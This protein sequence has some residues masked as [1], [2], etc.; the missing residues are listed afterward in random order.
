M[1]L[2]PALIRAALPRDR[3]YTLSDGGGMVLQ[4]TPQGRKR[5]RLR[6]RYC[7][8]P[9][10][11]SLGLYPEVGLRAARQQRAEARGLLA[12]G[13]NP[14]IERRTAAAEVCTFA[15]VAHDWLACLT[16][17]VEK[18]RRSPDVLRRARW[19]LNNHLLP[20]LGPRPIAKITAYELLG[21][22]KSIE[23]RGL[24]DTVR[25]VRQQASRILRHAVGLGY[26][27]YDLTAG[28][29]GLLLPPHPQHR[30]GITNPK[31]L[32]V[33]LRAVDSYRGAEKIAIALKLTPLL[34]V[35][36]GELRG[37]EWDEIDFERA[38]W[39]IPAERMK[40]RT[41]H[42]VPLCRQAL[43]FLERLHS[44]TG[45]GRYLFPAH[46]KPDRTMSGTRLA[47][48]LA[49]L[50]FSSREVTPHGFRA[51]ACT[52]LNELGWRADAIE[53]QLAHA[54]GDS[55]RRLYNHAQYLP[56]RTMMMQAWADYLDGLR[57]LAAGRREWGTK[58]CVAAEAASSASMP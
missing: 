36:P 5:W 23:S 44:L 33:L 13:F 14:S 30:P 8:I 35:R 6:Y 12:L 27:P 57:A 31:R 4:V 10:M 48:A 1:P 18:R 7:G 15:A 2:T 26:I 24:L 52:L 45:D 38:Q 29:R 49:S 20:A 39:R 42:L 47:A 25:R 17:I 28:F 54:V 19:V 51:T 3:L 43:E 58:C 37:A 53:R 9:N 16:R 21:V 55:A 41:P 34:F 50:G 22:L 32:G 40:M 46:G 11:I 56:E